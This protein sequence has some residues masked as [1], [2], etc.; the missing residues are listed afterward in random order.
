METLP[1]LK[2]QSSSELLKQQQ[3]QQELWPEIIAKIQYIQGFSNKALLTPEEV[4]FFAK[5]IRDEWGKRLPVAEIEQAF[6]LA[7][8]NKLETDTKNYNSLSIAYIENI[9]QAYMTY[10]HKF[11][12]PTSS[13]AITEKCELTDQEKDQIIWDGILTAFERFKTT[14]EKVEFGGIKYDF[15]KCRGMIPFTKE[16]RD[17]MMKLSRLRI[18]MKFEQGMV[19]AK[20]FNEMSKLKEQI[21]NMGKD[22]EAQVMEEAKTIAINTL[23]ADLV[24]SGSEINDLKPQQ[25]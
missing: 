8:K 6:I 10:K 19:K 17:E 9:L 7:A 12:V 20:T 22:F 1:Q 11:I 15:L 21:I 3:K 18:T 13:P 16:R 23:F 25:C 5:Y 2:N 14:G 4:T 24:E